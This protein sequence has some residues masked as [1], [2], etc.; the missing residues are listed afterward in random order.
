MLLSRSRADLFTNLRTWSHQVLVLCGGAVQPLHEGCHIGNKREQLR[1]HVLQI[2]LW[3][4]TVIEFQAVETESRHIFEFIVLC[5][6]VLGYVGANV[7]D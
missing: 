6:F 5:F 4:G 3:T 1:L 2:N 7:S